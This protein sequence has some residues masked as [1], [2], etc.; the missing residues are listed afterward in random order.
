VILLLSLSVF[1]LAGGSL[2]LYLST[3]KASWDMPEFIFLFVFWMTGIG[4]GMELCPQRWNEIAM[5]L[6]VFIGG[7]GVLSF[8]FFRSSLSML[9]F[10]TFSI[11]FL[12]WVGL[13][14][15][16]QI[17][18]ST[19]WVVLC[20]FFAGPIEKQTF[21]QGFLSSAPYE[22]W[23]FIFV[24]VVWAPLIEE[25]L[26]RGFFWEAIKRSAHQKIIISGVL[27]GMLHIDN[28]Y[29]VVPLCIFGIMLGILRERSGSIWV[30]MLAHF[31]NNT[32]VLFNIALS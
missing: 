9:G 13:V 32:I 17:L 28:V 5:P 7:C 22:R 18:V 25:V 20:S 19:L 11:R 1:V 16:T 2:G 27:F 23:A 12:P 10:R 4:I 21:V 14:T 31:L 8:S 29:S 24:I 3:E 6:G 15:I 26:M 30:P